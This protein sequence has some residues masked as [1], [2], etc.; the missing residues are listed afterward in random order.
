MKSEP[1]PLDLKE[2]F[3]EV[4]AVIEPRAKAKP[5]ELRVEMPENF[6]E[7][8]L[9]KRLTRITIE[10]LLTNAVK[11]TPVNGR[12]D[13]RVRVAGGTLTVEVVDTGCGIPKSEQDKIFGKQYRASN[14]RNT[15]EGNGFGL[16]AA[17]GAVE[18]QGG[19]I[20]F[21]SAEGKGTTFAI[22][23]PLQP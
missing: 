17:K 1:L 16:F 21:T 15:I 13:L 18:S 3:G 9:D 10:N 12:V 2:F 11:Y 8:R 22:T 19:T 6:P 5:V 7:A 14:V 23:L 20:S 4:L